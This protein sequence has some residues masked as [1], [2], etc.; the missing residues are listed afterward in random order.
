[1]IGGYVEEPDK[2]RFATNEAWAFERGARGEGSWSLVPYADGPAPGVRAQ[3][4]GACSRTAGSRAAGLGWMPAWHAAGRRRCLCTALCTLT[5][6]PPRAPPCSSAPT[7]PHRVAGGAGRRL[8]VAHRRLGPLAAGAPPPA[9]KAVCA[10]ARPLSPP[11]PRAGPAPEACAHARAHPAGPLTPHPRAPT[12]SWMT[13]GASTPRIGP[14]HGS[15]RRGT[16]SAAASP[17]SRP[18]RSAR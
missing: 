1:M 15:R 12:P 3:G 8:R 16:P 2:K 17:A 6:S 11:A 9:A 7:A 14:G 5:P 10:A 18:P 13:S 4:L